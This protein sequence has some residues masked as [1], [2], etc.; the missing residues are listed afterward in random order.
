MD[1]NRDKLIEEVAKRHSIYKETFSSATGKKVLE[2][3]EDSYFINK[4]TI[5]DT[6]NVD[7]YRIA[8]LE[9]QR[10]VVLRIK[11]LISDKQ[12]KQLGV[13]DASKKSR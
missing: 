7:P 11:N 10:A 6:D 1:S 13:K 8:F 5:R 4:S 3:L 2:D 12:L 9:G